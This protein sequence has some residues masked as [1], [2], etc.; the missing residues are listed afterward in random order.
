MKTSIIELIDLMI[1]YGKKHKISSGIKIKLYD[2]Q[3]GVIQ[4]SYSDIDIEEFEDIN[5]LIKILNN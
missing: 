1:G 2:D 5:D 4:P 3:S